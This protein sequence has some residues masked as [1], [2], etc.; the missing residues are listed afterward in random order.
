MQEH[1]RWDTGLGV[2]MYVYVNR[3]MSKT[4]ISEYYD[5]QYFGYYNTIIGASLSEPHTN[6]C[7]EK[8]AVLMYVAIHRPCVYS[9][10]AYV[11][12]DDHFH[13]EMIV[14]INVIILDEAS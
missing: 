11:N 1:L 8:I 14:K 5:W 10:C 2:F 6:H 12:V 4:T 3:I 7:Y 9:A 13:L